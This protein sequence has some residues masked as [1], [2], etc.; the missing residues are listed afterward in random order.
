MS[1]AA[2]PPAASKRDRRAPGLD[3]DLLAFV[4]DLTGIRGGYLVIVAT[5]PSWSKQGARHEVTV[6]GDGGVVG[7]QCDGWRFA[8][9]C[10]HT[11]HAEEIVRQYWREHYGALSSVDLCREDRWLAS[12]RP[13]DD[14]ESLR[15][16]ALGDCIA[17]RYLARHGRA[18]GVGAA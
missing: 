15:A 8:G 2:N 11:A 13:L 3:P 4:H 6:R 12:C 9:K 10:F 5:Y 1:A 18:A 16:D 7:C 17:A 14:A